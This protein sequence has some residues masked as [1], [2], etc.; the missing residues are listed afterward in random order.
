MNIVETELQCREEVH[1]LLLKIDFPKLIPEDFLSTSRREVFIS[2]EVDNNITT[3]CDAFS[4][5]SALHC[6]G[7]HKFRRISM[8]SSNGPSGGL[9]MRDALLSSPT[10]ICLTLTEASKILM[11]LVQGSLQ[12]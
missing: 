12:Y 10:Q 9:R 2:L 11:T 6:I 4:G 7:Q 5:S 1:A 3:H 8:L